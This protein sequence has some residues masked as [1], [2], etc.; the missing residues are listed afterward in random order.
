MTELGAEVVVEL[1]AGV[2]SGI[3]DAESAVLARQHHDAAWRRQENDGRDRQVVVNCGLMKAAEHSPIG[4]AAIFCAY[5]SV[6]VRGERTI[7][8][9]IDA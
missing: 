6:I 2:Q 9:F 7:C 4:K 3:L 1:S 8:S 5:N